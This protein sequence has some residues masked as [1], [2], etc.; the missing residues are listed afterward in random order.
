[1]SCQYAQER[2]SPLLDERVTQDERE[3]VLAHIEFC[4]NCKTQYDYLRDQR[5]GLQKLPAPAMPASL[6]EKLQV[7]ASHERARTLSRLT[8]Q[9][10]LE[11]FSANLRLAFDNIMRPFGLP[12]AS[13]LISAMALFALLAPSLSFARH[14]GDDGPTPVATYPQLEEVGDVGDYPQVEDP[15][16][17]GS[18]YEK[19]IE[20]KIS[21]TGSVWDWNVVKGDKELTPDL[22]QMILI[23]RFKPA[24]V[25]GQ[26]TW[27]V[28][29]ILYK[30]AYIIKG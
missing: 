12:A 18:S 2:L 27:G 6:R 9:A 22:K 26:P 7:M 10:R 30:H 17:F 3:V 16:S 11:D 1:M 20:L 24:T 5:L 14:G 15:D 28:V 8:M 21:P 4:R 25:F 13:G 19:V 23:A 29:R